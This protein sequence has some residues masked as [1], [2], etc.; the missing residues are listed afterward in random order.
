MIL[1][2]PTDLEEQ[3]KIANCLSAYDALI[4]AS[5]RKVEAVKRLKKAMLQKMF[6]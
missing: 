2:I 1:I 3:T 5:R 6:V 4:D